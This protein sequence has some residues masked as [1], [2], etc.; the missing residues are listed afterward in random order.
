LVQDIEGVL[1]GSPA[2]IEKEVRA[3]GCAEPYEFQMHAVALKRAVAQ[4]LA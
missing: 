2:S 3:A 4:A 1:S